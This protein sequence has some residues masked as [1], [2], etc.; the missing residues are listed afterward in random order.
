MEGDSDSAPSLGALVEHAPAGTQQR[1]I[2]CCCGSMQCAFLRHN[3][4]ALEG[5]E[6]DLM[7]AAQI[8]QVR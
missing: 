3:T 4:A 8:G 2:K 5:L 6:K 7:S 1:E